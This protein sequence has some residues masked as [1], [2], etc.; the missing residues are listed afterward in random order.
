M[1]TMNRRKFLTVAGVSA[2]A[3]A[4]GGA[5]I[6]AGTGLLSGTGK[7][8]SLSFKAVAGLPATP[9]PNYCTYV[10]EGHLDLAAKTGSVTETMYAGYP[11]AMSDTVWTG[12]T[13]IIRVSSVRQSGGVLYVEGA[14]TDRSQ[15]RRGENPTFKLQIDQA[16]HTAQG[17]F[18]G[19]AVSL[20]LA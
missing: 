9:L 4:A 1:A 10:I 14:V 12:F 3:V 18:I 8:A 13:R 11:T 16:A 6:A 19:K 7:K 20:T 17:E 15:L 5:G 2:A